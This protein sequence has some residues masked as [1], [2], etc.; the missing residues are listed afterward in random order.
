MSAKRI[1][2]SFTKAQADEVRVSLKGT[3]Q[4]RLENGMDRRA[5]ENALRELDRAEVASREEK[6]HD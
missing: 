2:P 3:I 1:T 4:F 5:A 6:P